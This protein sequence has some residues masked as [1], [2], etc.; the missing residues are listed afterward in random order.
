MALSNYRLT[1]GTRWATFSDMTPPATVSSGGTYTAAPYR[2][3]VSAGTASFAADA[4]HLDGTQSIK[5]TP[6]QASQVIDLDFDADADLSAVNLIHFNIKLNSN[7]WGAVDIWLNTADD[8]SFTNGYRK[9]MRNNMQNGMSAWNTVII[10]KDDWNT[11]GTPGGW[12]NI[13]RIRLRITALA[14]LTPAY[15]GDCWYGITTKPNIIFQMDDGANTQATI[16]KAVFDSYG[17]KGGLNLISGP[18]RTGPLGSYLS[19]A[20]IQDFYASGWDLGV[21]GDSTGITNWSVISQADC[22]LEISRCHDWFAA[23]V[24][25]RG[26]SDW[27]AHPGGAYDTESLA[28]IAAEGITYARGTVN[29]WQYNSTALGIA[30]REDLYSFL[31]DGT[32]TLAEFETQWNK[33]IKY[34][35]T[36]FL[37]LHQFHA[38]TDAAS[39]LSVATLNS[40][41]TAAKALK[42]AGTVNILTPTEWIAGMAASTDTLTNAAGPID[43]Q[44]NRGSGTGTITNAA[45]PDL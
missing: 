36:I 28:A 35:T 10:H 27:C 40:I 31:P 38:T 12:Q 22:Q 30:N 16:G 25:T 14:A 39:T 15:I 11:S 34:G 21:H 7:D 4:D 13:K 18:T 19:L 43:A 20:Q 1:A 5:V 23:Q 6:G 3:N 37:C 26:I 24:G 42:D 9:S 33:A 32:P 44:R 8:T 29:D 2:I 45:G 41:L 17:I